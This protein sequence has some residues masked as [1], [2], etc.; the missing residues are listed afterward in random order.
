MIVGLIVCGGV[1]G[2]DS[3][4]IKIFSCFITATLTDTEYLEAFKIEA[5]ERILL[6]GG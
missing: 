1:G 5:Q 6:G 3:P 2:G 4:Y